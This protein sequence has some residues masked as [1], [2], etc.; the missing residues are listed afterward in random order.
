[1][2]NNQGLSSVHV[3]KKFTVDRWGDPNVDAKK[4]AMHPVV[5]VS[6]VFP[7][8]Q[9]VNAWQTVNIQRHTR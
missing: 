7:V 1:M 3:T 4:G 2:K 6:Q 8:D 9:T 5:A